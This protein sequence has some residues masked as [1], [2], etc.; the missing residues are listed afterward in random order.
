MPQLLRLRFYNVGPERARMEDLT[1]SLADIVTGQ[2]AHS[3][4]WL[5]NG[6]GKTTLISLSLW[7]LCPDKP[8]PDKNQIEDYVQPDDRS[9]LVAEWQMDKKDRQLSLWSGKPERYLTGVFCEWRASAS[10]Q[11]GRKLHRMF[12][13]ARVLDDEPRLSLED[14]PLYAIRQG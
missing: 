5:R 1:I 7:L 13:A 6:G 2:A 8:M 14:L 3:A 12:F 10:S 9:V 11:E 4:I